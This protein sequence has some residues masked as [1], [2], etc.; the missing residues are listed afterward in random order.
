MP[1]LPIKV[2]RAKRKN[3]EYQTQKKKK[4]THIHTIRNDDGNSGYSDHILDTGDTYGTVTY[5]VDVTRRGRKGRHLNILEKYH[6]YKLSRDNLHMN[7]IY[8]DIYNL[9]FQT[10]HRLC[11]T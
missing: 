11:D 1:R 7:D 4:H 2:H 8:I 6:I 5:T 3:T 9:I 10:L